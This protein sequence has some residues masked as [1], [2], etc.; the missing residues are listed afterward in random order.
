MRENV[1][2]TAVC[3]RFG[4][5]FLVAQAAVREKHG[6][7]TE[8]HLQGIF[9]RFRG[10]RA[11][12]WWRGGGRRHKQEADI[13]GQTKPQELD[14]TAALWET[15]SGHESTLHRAT[16]RSVAPMRGRRLFLYTSHFL[17]SLM[18]DLCTDQSNQVKSA[19]LFQSRS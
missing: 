3:E 16:W 14:G 6:A 15:G 12:C 4:F 13:A 5:F 18:S 9:L 2:V 11:M 10:M 8:G 7:H 17:R 19:D 1:W